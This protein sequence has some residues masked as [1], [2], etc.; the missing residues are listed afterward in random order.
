[1]RLARRPSPHTGA[2]AVTGTG[3]VT[4]YLVGAAATALYGYLPVPGGLLL[5]LLVAAGGLALADRW[6]AGLLGG[7]S[8]FLGVTEDEPV[9]FF[10]YADQDPFYDALG[11]GTRENV[12]GQANADIRT[13]LALISPSSIDD[14]W[15]GVVGPHELVHLAFNTARHNP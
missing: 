8:R 14:P 4:L 5:A 3:I 7:G 1:M 10:I 9:D 12:G 2:P 13:L 11:P 6:R 15:V